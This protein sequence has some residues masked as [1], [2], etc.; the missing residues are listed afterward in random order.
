M[1]NISVYLTFTFD[2]I[3]YKISKYNL[4]KNKQEY[5]IL[6]KNYYKLREKSLY[7]IIKCFEP[8][9]MTTEETKFRGTY[10]QNTD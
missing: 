10:S 2:H 8:D 4:S 7:S 5:N 3:K 9:K 6:T 1:G